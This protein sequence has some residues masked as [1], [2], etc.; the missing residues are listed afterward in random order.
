MKE[1]SSPSQS[2]VKWSGNACNSQKS[3][4]RLIPCC[5]PQQ[6][7]IP[8]GGLQH[9]PEA[10]LAAVNAALA[11]QQKRNLA[12]AE[13]SAGM[14]GRIACL[15]PVVYARSSMYVQSIWDFEC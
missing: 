12:F 7:Q 9:L 8:G 10:V 5:L 11:N 1:M 2:A 3:G 4:I 13:D 15:Q 14:P 6:L